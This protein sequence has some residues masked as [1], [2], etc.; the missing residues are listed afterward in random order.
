MRENEGDL[1]LFC[2]LFTASLIC[3]QN[4]RDEEFNVR[5]QMNV[6]GEKNMFTIFSMRKSTCE[7]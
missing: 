6:C 2:L 5:Y 1:F 3:A 4:Y 7:R